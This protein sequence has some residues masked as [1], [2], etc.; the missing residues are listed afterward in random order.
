MKADVVISTSPETQRQLASAFRMDPTECPILRY[1]R[2]GMFLWEEDARADFCTCVEGP[3]WLE[4]RSTLASAKNWIY[5]P[6]WRASERIF[7]FP[8]EEAGPV[9]GDGAGGT[10]HRS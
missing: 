8:W 10:G 1:P 3:D 6:T 7:A 9:G 2:T 5:M 4:E